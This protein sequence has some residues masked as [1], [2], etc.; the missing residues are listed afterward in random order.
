MA[1]GLKRVADPE[2]D[3]NDPL[4]YPRRSVPRALVR[5][6]GRAVLPLL[7]KVTV[8]GREHFPEGGPLLVV[9]NHRA[10]MEAVLLAVYTPWQFEPLGAA[11]VP[12]E[13]FVQWALDLYGYIPVNRGH[14][15]RRALL[16]ALGV[17]RQGGIVA[18]FPEGGIWNA[19][20][21]RA[22]TGVAWLSYRAEAPVLPI[23]FGGTLGALKRGL[24]LARPRLTVRVGQV[25]PAACLPG[26]QPRKA[27]LQAFAARTVD[28]IEALLPIAE[29]GNGQR[30]ENERFALR[31]S[32]RTHDGEDIDYPDE[33]SLSHADA[34]AELLH[35]PA[36]LK[37]F[38]SNLN[39]PTAPLQRLDRESDPSVLSEAAKAILAY[40]EADNP[41]LLTYRFGPSRAAAMEQGLQELVEL[42]RWAAR[43][44][45]LLE[46]TPVRRYSTPDEGKDIVQVEQGAF[47]GWM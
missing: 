33:L 21:M 23:G 36:V 7:F 15:D 31:A 35:R 12:H 19:G 47:K 10:V 20:R 17:L 27:Y 45:H 18:I 41:Y 13:A 24:R 28:A 3:G 11:D 37:I 42:A 29:R 30:I 9:G 46:L 40:L 43:S 22:Q 32:V 39:L 34:L 38:T 16:Q 25:I 5:W 6:L 4:P 44:G 8:S 26:D 14:F 1:E 2:F